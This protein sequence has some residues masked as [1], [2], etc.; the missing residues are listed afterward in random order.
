MQDVKRGYRRDCTFLRT[1][2]IIIV[3]FRV[4]TDVRLFIWLPIFFTFI[5]ILETE[6]MRKLSDGL[7][8]IF[9]HPVDFAET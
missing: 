6:R 3:I 7:E 1:P 5:L 4:Y 9:I 8:R 2:D